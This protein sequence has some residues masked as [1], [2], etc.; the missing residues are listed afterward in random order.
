MAEQQVGRKGW[1]ARLGE[2][3]AARRQKLFEKGRYR[4]ERYAERARR[5]EIGRYGQGDDSGL[6]NSAS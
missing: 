4:Q 2:R 3:R 5:G 6:G 1:R